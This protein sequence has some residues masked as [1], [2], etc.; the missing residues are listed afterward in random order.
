MYS[1]QV[2]NINHKPIKP[3]LTRILSKQSKDEKWEYKCYALFRVLTTFFIVKLCI[4]YTCMYIAYA[5]LYESLYYASPM[6]FFLLYKA[7]S[8]GHQPLYSFLLHAFFQ[9]ILPYYLL[10]TFCSGTYT[11][12]VGSAFTKHTFTFSS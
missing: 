10:I 9:L 6:I 4:A 7:G 5:V 12:Q 2:K 11:T 3:Y 8:C 1:I